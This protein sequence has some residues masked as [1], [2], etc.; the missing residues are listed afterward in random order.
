[1][2]L[3]GNCVYIVLIG[4]SFKQVLDFELEVNWNI[5]Y[6]IAVILIPLVILGE[7]RRLKYLVPLSVVANMCIIATFAITLYY[8]FIGD[9][10]VSDKPSFSSWDK[11][12]IFFR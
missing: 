9:L 6:Y 1:M 11:L 8:I 10:N 12:P 5:R 2:Y 7:I 4:R 3:G